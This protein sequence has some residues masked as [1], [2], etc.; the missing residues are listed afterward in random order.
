MKNEENDTGR[1]DRQGSLPNPLRPS[2]NIE[3]FQTACFIVR[4]AERG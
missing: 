4:S 2:E 1:V 3:I